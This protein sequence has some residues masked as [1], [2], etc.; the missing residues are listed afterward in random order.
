MRTILKTVV[1]TLLVT[2]LF[3]GCDNDAS[4]IDDCGNGEIDGVEE[5][6]TDVFAQGS[7]C[8]DYGYTSGTLSCASDCK[9][10]LTQCSGLTYCGNGEIDEGEEC[11]TDIFS[12]G[13]QCSDYGYA[14]GTLSCASDCKVDL[15]QCFGS[16]ECGNGE[17]D[18]GEE[19]D[20]DVFAHGDLCLD[21]GFGYNPGMVACTSDCV[22]DLS[23]CTETGQCSNGV[24]EGSEECDTDDFGE[25]SCRMLGFNGG[26]LSCNDDCT[27]DISGCEET[28]MCGDG[29]LDEGYEECD[30]DYMAETTCIDLGYE[31]GELRCDEYCHFDVAFCEAA[32]ICGDGIYNDGYEECDGDDFNGKTCGDYGYT[33]PLGYLFCSDEC[34]MDTSGCE[35]G[36]FCGDGVYDEDSEECDG[37]DLGG[38][39]CEDYGY[40][41]GYFV[42]TEYCTLDESNCIQ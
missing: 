33:N 11:D 24:R 35:Y 37:S 34:V 6:D 23:P 32:G 41:G 31:R 4:E 16:P 29:N 42:C 38:K 27:V 13:S 19:C 10:D 21:Y 18:E 3:S 15:T 28:G 2:G 7:Q 39:K 40:S 20:S 5:C 8:S 1:I 30:G 9:V 26:A 14:S 17:I 25:S 22:L 36:S 12:Q